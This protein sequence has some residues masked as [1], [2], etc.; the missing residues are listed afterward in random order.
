MT[1]L[2]AAQAAQQ[3]NRSGDG[4]YAE[5]AAAE[6]NGILLCGCTGDC[7]C[8]DRADQEVAAFDAQ[9]ARFAEIRLPR[10]EA[11]YE[12]LR[13]SV[14]RVTPVMIVRSYGWV[15]SGFRDHLKRVFPNLND[16]QLDELGRGV[17]F[18]S[19]VHEWLCADRDGERFRMAA[20]WD[21][22]HPSSPSLVPF[23]SPRDPTGEY[24]VEEE[25]L[26]HWSCRVGD[27]LRDA[28]LANSEQAP[29]ARPHSFPHAS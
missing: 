23:T 10:P 26:D 20:S 19:V 1:N 14:T 25:N 9:M 13:D 7:S 16:G 6:P 17:T 18:A 15:H 4:R 28:D 22:A 24:S 21:R 11:A 12:S 5:R 8:R 2:S 3:H 27:L 29:M